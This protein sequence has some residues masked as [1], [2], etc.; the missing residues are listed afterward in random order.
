DVERSKESLQNDIKR[1]SENANRCQ[2][3]IGNLLSF[4]RASRNRKDCV[5]VNKISEAS[6]ALLDHKIK[7]IGDVKLSKNFEKDIPD[8]LGDFHQIEQVLVNIIRNAF[9]SIGEKEG[10]R[11]IEV[12]TFHK[13]KSVFI[14]ISNNG[15]NIPEDTFSDIFEP[16][17]T[18]KGE[19]QGTGLGL[20]I[21]KTIVESHGGSISVS[22]KPDELTTFTIELPVFEGKRKICE[23]VKKHKITKSNKILVVDDEEDVLTLIKKILEREKQKV[24]TVSSAEE[25]IVKLKENNYDIILSDIEMKPLDGFGLFNEVN[26]LPIK[27]RFVF[28]TGS[29]LTKE[30]KN[31]I[32]DLKVVCLEKPFQIDELLSIL[33]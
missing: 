8:V 22:S 11:K 17:V 15:A 6:L 13:G 32:K 18:T 19:G 28:M 1:I 21:C 10:E 3:I 7:S 4:V 23:V 12:S 14:K 31:K 27:S 16:F 33:D 29:L 25:A 30:L 5:N 9:D 26:K 24:D 2:A 20:S